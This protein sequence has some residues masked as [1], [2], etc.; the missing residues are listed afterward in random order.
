MVEVAADSLEAARMAA[1]LGAD[2]IELCQV[3]EIGGLTPSRALIEAVV[4]AVDRPVVVMIRPRAGDFVVSNDDL[5]IMAA[6][7]A[8]S[9]EAGCRGIATGALRPDRSIDTHAMRRL[10]DAAG[11]LPVTFHRA[12]DL[13]PDPLA[14]VAELIALGV[15]RVLTAGG[16]AVPGRASRG[17]GTGGAPAFEGR[18]RIALLVDRAGRSL[19]VI[20]GGGIRG[21]Q[22]A[23]LVRE[24]KVSEIHLSAVARVPFE[25]RRGFGMNTQPDEDRLA[26]VLEALDHSFGRKGDQS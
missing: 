5:A 25:P 4:A 8:S 19:T 24:S 15:A 26:G 22:V 6:D 16:R 2:R 23:A 3:L 11:D 1:R 7:I 20:A 14:A 12:F 18:R 9:I 17:R 21:E 13:V 10:L